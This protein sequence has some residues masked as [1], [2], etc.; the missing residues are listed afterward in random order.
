MLDRAR[1]RG[2]PYC[3]V[4]CRLACILLS[5]QRIQISARPHFFCI[6]RAGRANLP[7]TSSP[8]ERI[9]VDLFCWLWIFIY[10]N[11]TRLSSRT[12]N[13]SAAAA[14]HASF[15]PVAGCDP[16]PTKKRYSQTPN[17]KGSLYLSSSRERWYLP[18]PPW[19]WPW[20]CA[21]PPIFF[22]ELIVPARPRHKCRVASGSWAQRSDHS[23]HGLRDTDSRRRVRP[24]DETFAVSCTARGQ[25]PAHP[26]H[27]VRDFFFK[28]CL[29]GIHHPSPII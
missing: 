14:L 18:P 6:L 26:A 2:P 25:Y 7:P 4:K 5:R 8:C 28:F 1:G 21:D 16:S 10:L 3:G 27:L 15:I 20:P 23:S 17:P 11:D 29:G 12:K 22:F 19:P 24:P 13:L 9:F